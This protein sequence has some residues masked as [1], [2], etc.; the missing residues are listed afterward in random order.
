MRPNRQQMHLLI[1]CQAVG[2][3]MGAFGPLLVVGYTIYVLVGFAAGF[4]GFDYFMPWWLA[5][6]LFGL[7]LMLRLEFLFPPAVFVGT[8]LAWEWH[9]LAALLFA[10][11]GLIIVIPALTASLFGSFAERLP[12]ARS[13]RK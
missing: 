11:P 2:V 3:F 13:S 5:V 12:F 4:S 8:W 1:V 7:T 9:W 10:A 6:V